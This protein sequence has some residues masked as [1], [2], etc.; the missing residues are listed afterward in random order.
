MTAIIV[1]AVVFSFAMCA[2]GLGLAK[3]GKGN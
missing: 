2:L 3:A 1:A